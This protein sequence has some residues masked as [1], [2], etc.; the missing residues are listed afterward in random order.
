VS[1][2]LISRYDKL[3][4][5][6]RELIAERDSLLEIKVL[7]QTLLDGSSPA[8]CATAWVNSFDMDNLEAALGDKP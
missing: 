4:R 2:L 6:N 3:L 1:E 5:T 7:A 8:T